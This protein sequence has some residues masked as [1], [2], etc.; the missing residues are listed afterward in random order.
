ML[1]HLSTI[2]VFYCLLAEEEV[3]VITICQRSNKIGCWKIYKM[4]KWCF[5]I[6]F[7]LFI[8]I[9]YSTPF[10]LQKKKTSYF[11]LYGRWFNNEKRITYNLD[12]SNRIDRCVMALHQFPM[13]VYRSTDQTLKNHSPWHYTGLHLK[14][15]KSRF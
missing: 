6:D 11:I 7:E 4:Y 14:K 12:V 9:M 15:D 2:D 10:Y 3:H 1:T 13:F 5:Q 8:V